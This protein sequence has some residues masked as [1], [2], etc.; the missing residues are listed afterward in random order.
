M[1]KIALI[2]G[3]DYYKHVSPLHGC[4]NDAHEVDSMLKRNDGGDI[5]FNT[6]LVTSSGPSEFLSKR[7]LKALVKKHFIQKAD[8]S[9]FYFAGHGHVE[10]TGGYLVASDAQS[11]DDGLSLNDIMKL[12]NDSPAVNKIIILDSCFS[13]VA[14]ASIENTAISHLSEGMTILTAST[15][16]QYASEENGR[17]VFTSLMVDALSGSAANLVGQVTPGSIYAH[18]DQSLGNWGDQRPIFKTNVENF[19]C[20]RQAKPAISLEDL[21]SITKYFPSP[22][23][24]FQL[25]PTF[26][27]EM[28]GREEG[29]PEPIEANT[30][31]FKCLQKFNR[32][33]LLVPINAPHMWNAAMESRTCKL[34]A[35][36]EH[37]RRLVA[38]DLI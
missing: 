32:V 19:V 2:V 20:L 27:P 11:G 7:E 36:G 5:N 1:K 9:L 14:G 25:D 38:K 22:G 21:Q 16:D 23:F 28:R 13:G 29:M 26:E 18:I 10:T 4:V 31:I 35:L 24:E 30:I 17:G 8:V 12:A 37:Y 34:T 6:K 15:K 3:V 33:N